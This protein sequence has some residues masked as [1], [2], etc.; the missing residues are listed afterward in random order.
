MAQVYSTQAEGKVLELE[1]QAERKALRPFAELP[2]VHAGLFDDLRGHFG[3]Q[4]TLSA[5]PVDL[6]CSHPSGTRLW[7]LI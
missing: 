6:N 7:L 3:D 2:R 4:A 1:E 5:Y